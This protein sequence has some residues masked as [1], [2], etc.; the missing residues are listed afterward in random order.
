MWQHYEYYENNQ[1]INEETK[2]QI[3]D[4]IL[5]LEQLTGKQRGLY[6]KVFDYL[7]EAKRI[8]FNI[9]VIMANNTDINWNDIFYKS[10]KNMTLLLTE[11]EIEDIRHIAGM[12]S[13][14]RTTLD[15]TLKKY[16]EK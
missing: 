16:K 14:P 13:K 9:A 6:K 8:Y 11:G 5:K 10:R 12:L 7:D 15:E 2:E 3:N 4:Y 1:K